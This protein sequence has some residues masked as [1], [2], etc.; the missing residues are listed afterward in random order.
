MH[1]TRVKNVIYSG[2]IHNKQLLILFV[3]NTIK[4]Y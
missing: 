3:L 4:M 1:E 2:W